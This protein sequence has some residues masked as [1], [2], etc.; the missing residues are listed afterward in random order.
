MKESNPETIHV[1]DR[2]VLIPTYN[3]VDNVR[4]LHS[5]LRGVCDFDLLF[6]DDSSP[7]G[8]AAVIEEIARNDSGVNLLQRKSKQG[9]GEA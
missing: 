4:M 1:S 3:E 9:L 7:D 5:A 6:I 2:I 8:T